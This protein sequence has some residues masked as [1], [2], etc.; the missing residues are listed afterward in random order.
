MSAFAHPPAIASVRSS[1]GLVAMVVLRVRRSR[2]LASMLPALL[3]SGAMTLALVVVMQV[4]QG[5][6]AEGFS[7]RWLE[8]WLIA[9]PIAF[10]VVYVLGSLLAWMMSMVSAPA[11]RVAARSSGLAF[12]DIA[13]ASKRVTARHG[14]TVLRGLKRADDFSGV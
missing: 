12:D 7:G 6:A 3:S 14:F 13:D 4:M 1:G 9:W 5:G 11:K 8:S 10:P 2:A